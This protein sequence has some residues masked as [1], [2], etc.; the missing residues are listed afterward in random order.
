MRQLFFGHFLT[1]LAGSLIYLF[2]RPESIAIFKLIN[3]HAS[4]SFISEIKDFTL[5]YK[6]L[7]PEWSIYSLPAGLWMFS[8]TTLILFIWDNKINIKNIFWLIILPVISVYIEIGQ[9]LNLNSGT[10]D[11]VDFVFY[12]IGTA[13]SLLLYAKDFAINKSKQHEELY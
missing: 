3:I 2:F 8:C 10:F 5:K 4:D 9:Y 6:Y 13:L 1:L 11:I 12:L 7:I